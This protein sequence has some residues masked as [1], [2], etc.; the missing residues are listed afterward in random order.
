MC[1]SRPWGGSVSEKGFRPGPAALGLGEFPGTFERF[2]AVVGGH[3]AL[4]LDELFS[5][6]RLDLVTG[7]QD[8]EIAGGALALLDQSRDRGLRDDA[9]G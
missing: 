9:Q 5:L 3:H 4:H 1:R 6:H 2:G 8:L 7:L